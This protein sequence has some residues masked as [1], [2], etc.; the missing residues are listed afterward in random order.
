MNLELMDCFGTQIQATFFK[1]AVDKFDSV[2]KEQ[3]IYLFSNGS[4]KIANQKFTSI[5]NDFCLVFDKQADIVEV[6]DDSSIQEKGFNFIPMKE[7]ILIDRT[8]TID[9]IG[10]LHRNGELID[11]ELKSG[12]KKEKRTI[13]VTDEGG[14]TVQ[15]CLWGDIAH[16]F[17]MIEGN[18]VIG[19]KG[20]RVVEYQGKSLN[21]SE[22]AYIMF[23]PPHLRTKEL[24]AWYDS[25]PNKDS[26]KSINKEDKVAR[27]DNTRM[28]CEMN[29]CLA[30]GTGAGF[31]IL[32][33]YISFVKN[34]DKTY[35]L[36]C[37]EENCRRKVIEVQE[38]NEEGMPSVTKYKCEHCNK[39]YDECMP[40]YMLLAK[41][42]DQTD[43]VFVNFYRE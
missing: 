36:A 28:I 7:I 22:D 33:C 11:C 27:F 18:P 19:I 25:L 21:I 26:L 42:A 17:D 15:I 5:K 2:I 29:D 38:H 24:R 6:P 12:M 34:D 32:N 9:V 40:T 23:D 8:K 10:I 16:K 35:Y 3:G 14:F 30:N 1:D 4:V 37:Q 43:T 39:V 20:A 41:L 13:C 31:F